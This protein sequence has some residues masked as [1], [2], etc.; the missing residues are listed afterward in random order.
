MIV[1]V[2]HN[3]SESEIKAAVKGGLDDMHLLREN[4]GIGTCCGKCKSCTKKILRECGAEDIRQRAD[5]SK[6]F[7]ISLTPVF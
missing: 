3:I 7:F 1:C 2:C 4:L 5:D 6:P